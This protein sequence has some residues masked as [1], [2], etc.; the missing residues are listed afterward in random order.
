M[1][2]EAERIAFGPLETMDDYRIALRLLERRFNQVVTRLR[3]VEQQIAD[4]QKAG[5]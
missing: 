3:T 2:A 4:L 1:P 5:S